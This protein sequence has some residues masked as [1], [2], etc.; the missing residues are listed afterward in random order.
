MRSLP[1]ATSIFLLLGCGAGDQTRSERPDAA[2]APLIDVT[3]TVNACP[4]FA[5]ALVLPQ[6]VPLGTPAF[7][8]ARAVDP[9][10]D[11]LSLS[12]DWTSSSG[13]FSAPH[14]AVTEYRCAEAGVQTLT[15]VTRDIGDCDATLHVDVTCLS[16]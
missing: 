11:D 16:E 15:V 1:L 9:D 7:V 4:V 3:P 12:Y 6:A 10:A 2:D 8:S 13:T 14:G 5:A